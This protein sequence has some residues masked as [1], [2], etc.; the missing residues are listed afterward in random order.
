MCIYSG[1][2]RFTSLLNPGWGSWLYTQQ[3]GYVH[4]GTH[5]DAR[6]IG[7][8]KYVV[9]SSFRAGRLVCPPYRATRILL[10]HCLFLL[11]C[12]ENHEVIVLGACLSHSLA[13]L[14]SYKYIFKNYFHF[15]H[16]K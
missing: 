11:Y 15:K 9:F 10:T 1:V 16:S 2:K 3:H 13:I 6:G 7:A 4:T 8:A 5:T 14:E 12:I